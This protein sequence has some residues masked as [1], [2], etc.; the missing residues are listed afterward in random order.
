M[1]FT[2]NRS[3]SLRFALFILYFIALTEIVCLFSPKNDEEFD[4]SAPEITIDYLDPIFKQKRI[5][6][7]VYECNKNKKLLKSLESS[8]FSQL[9]WASYGGPILLRQNESSLGETSL[10][11]YFKFTKDDVSI[12]IDMQV[13]Q[14]KDFLIEKIQNEHNI[15]N[16]RRDQ[17][18]NLIPKSLS[19]RTHF[20]DKSTGKRVDLSG[21]SYFLESFPLRVD[22]MIEEGTNERESLEKI[23]KESQ[24]SRNQED[25]LALRFDCELILNDEDTDYDKKID[26]ESDSYLKINMNEFNEKFGLLDL[27]FEKSSYVLVLHEQLVGLTNQ[28]YK[29]MNIFDEYGLNEDEFADVFLEDLLKQTSTGVRKFVDFKDLNELSH[30]N[31]DDAKI[32]VFKL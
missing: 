14:H 24:I 31:F 8:K 4:L 18:E 29:K 15:P 26:Q 5:R 19:C 7:E 25:F 13:N 6:L 20:L 10:G 30:F 21:Q 32:K 3:K 17:I 12:R 23:I 11:D 16:L 22:F 9:K 1:I 27:L 28:F 2:N